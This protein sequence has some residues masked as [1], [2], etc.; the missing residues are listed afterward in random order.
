MVIAAFL[1]FP[2][3][4]RQ[5]RVNQAALEMRV[6]A[7]NTLTVYGGLGGF[8]NFNGIDTNTAIRAKFVPA[9]MVRGNEIRTALGPVGL[10]SDEFGNGTM[11]Y[12]FKMRIDGAG[13]SEDDCVAFAT[14]M[15]K[16]PIPGLVLMVQNSGTAQTM[17]CVDADGSWPA[18]WHDGANQERIRR[19]CANPAGGISVK[20]GQ[21]SWVGGV[22]SYC[23]GQS[24]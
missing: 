8:A 18:G 16:T 1:I 4:S 21:S 6:F 15:G 11:A 20:F 2:N 24:A 3:I 19:G 14:A 10:V 22:M 23:A 5:V 13:L 9:A 7:T 17:V 12:G